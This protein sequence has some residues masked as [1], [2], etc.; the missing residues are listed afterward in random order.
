MQNNPMQ[1]MQ[2]MQGMASGKT[3]PMQAMMG[4][5]MQ[6]MQ[7]NYKNNPLF[8]K[9]QEMGKGK[10]NAEVMSV[11]RNLCETNGLDFDQ[12]WGMFQQS[13]FGSTR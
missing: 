7:G 1:M 4:M 11:A 8:Q 12:M 9:A 5:F 6:Q 3:N 13:G 2:M 10:S